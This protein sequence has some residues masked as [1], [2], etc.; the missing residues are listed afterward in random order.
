MAARAAE[1]YAALQLPAFDGIG[2][3]VCE[4][5]VIDALLGFGAEV[6]DI[7]T[8]RSQITYQKFFHFIACVV[9]GNTYFI[10]R[11]LV[12]YRIRFLFYKYKEK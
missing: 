6:E 1:S 10:H 5:G 11:I 4:I 2:Q 8:L 7:P 12:L 3:R 9:A